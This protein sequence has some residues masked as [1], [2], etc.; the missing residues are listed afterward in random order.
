[1][2]QAAPPS[3]AHLDLGKVA[4][5]QIGD[6]PALLGRHGLTP[7]VEKVLVEHFLVHVVALEGGG[8]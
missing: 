5:L 4:L 6:L 1:M 2:A 3:S 7:V 8:G